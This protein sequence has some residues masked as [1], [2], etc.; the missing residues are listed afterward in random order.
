MLSEI[1]LRDCKNPLQAPGVKGIGNMSMLSNLELIRR[2]PLFARSVYV[3][4]PVRLR[5]EKFATPLIGVTV[6]VP[7]SGVIVAVLV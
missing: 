4:F 1:N 6:V 2:V 7:A 3:P 5:P